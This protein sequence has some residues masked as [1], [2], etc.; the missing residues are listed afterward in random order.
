MTAIVIIYKD[1]RKMH[2][3]C[4]TWTQAF[5]VARVWERKGY[6]VEVAKIL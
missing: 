2:R 4:D 6:R 3:F 1:G 5:T